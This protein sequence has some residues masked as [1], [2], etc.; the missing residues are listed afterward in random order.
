MHADT[1]PRPA[2]WGRSR[3]PLQAPLDPSDELEG[4]YLTSSAMIGTTTHA[5]SCKAADLLRSR[6]NA[7]GPLCQSTPSY[8][9]ATRN[10]GQAK[11]S[12]QRRPVR[13]M[14]S[15]C[16]T[17]GGRPPS[18]MTRRAS[19]SI[20]DSASGEA[21]GRSSRTLTTPRRPDCNSMAR[22]SSPRLHVVLRSAASRVASARG[23]SRLR[24]T[25]IAVHGGAVAGR[26]RTT[27]SGA[28]SRRCTTRPRVECKRRPPGLST[29]RLE[30]SSVSNP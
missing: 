23:R 4:R 24:A 5:V 9:A 11:S 7:S 29:C 1:P 17:G 22:A 8:S 30:V 10:S 18:I 19:L 20:G 21:R 28:P 25:S 2:F 13:S 26:P 14:S 12:R 27:V 6:R 16:S 3:R 15:Y